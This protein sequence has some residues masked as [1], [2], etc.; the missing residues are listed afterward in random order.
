M[1]RQATVAD[2]DAVEAIYSAIHDEE[3]AGRASVGW[4][5]AIYPT[6]QTAETALEQGELFV[7]EDGGEIVGAGVL[8]QTQPEQYAECV[9]TYPALPSQ[10]L[11]LHTLVIAPDCAGKGYGKEFVAFYEAYA[12]GLGCTALRIDTQEKTRAARGLYA[13]L[14]FREAGCVYGV[15]SGMPGITLICLEKS[16]SAT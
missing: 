14:G 1:I 9:W 5:R 11:V 7:L 4:Q 6:R 15:F 2:L 12:K 10:V 3:E 16:L 13:R 8:N